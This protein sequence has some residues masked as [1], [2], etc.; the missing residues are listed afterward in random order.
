MTDAGED[1]VVPFTFRPYV[2][3]RIVPY[4]DARGTHAR[5][6]SHL[7]HD[8]HWGLSELHFQETSALRLALHVPHLRQPTHVRDRV[9]A[10]GKKQVNTL[11]TANQLGNQTLSTEHENINPEH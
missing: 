11:S 3:K 6:V 10:G 8:A 5:P 7:E 1:A 9:D 2:H 4:K